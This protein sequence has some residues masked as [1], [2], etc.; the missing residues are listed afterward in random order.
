M[1]HFAQQSSNPLFPC[2]LFLDKLAIENS[3]AVNLDV[4][5]C[6]LYGECMVN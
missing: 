2:N 4:H 3:A 1:K 5:V 6:P